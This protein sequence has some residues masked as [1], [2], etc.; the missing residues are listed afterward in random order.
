M[1]HLLET[2]YINLSPD[3]PLPT[4]VEYFFKLKPRYVLFCKNGVFKGLVTLKDI[5]EIAERSTDE[6][7]RMSENNVDNLL[8]DI[9]ED[10]NAGDVIFRNEMTNTA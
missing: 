9:E 4:L 10:Y 2:N 8:E 7:L 6:L 5:S 1:H 3:L